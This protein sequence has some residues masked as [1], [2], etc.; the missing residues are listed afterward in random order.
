M[1]TGVVIAFCIFTTLFL[2]VGCKAYPKPDTTLDVYIEESGFFVISERGGES[3][4][5]RFNVNEIHK[6][7]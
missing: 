2:L 3:I 7:D 5:V 1:N 4:G 6:H